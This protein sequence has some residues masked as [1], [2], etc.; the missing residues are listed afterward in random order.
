MERE[1]ALTKKNPVR[2][3]SSCGSP[4]IGKLFSLQSVAELTDTSVSSWRR[5]VEKREIKYVKVGKSVRIPADAISEYIIE[6]PSLDEE[7]LNI[8]MEE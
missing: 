1:M 4:R 6:L 2:Y 8:L 7:T 5:R 3:C